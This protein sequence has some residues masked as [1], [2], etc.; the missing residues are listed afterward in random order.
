MTK[1]AGA[2]IGPFHVGTKSW[3]EPPIT[4]ECGIRE[5]EMEQ[6][7]VATALLAAVAAF[8]FDPSSAALVRS[9][10]ATQVGPLT[11]VLPQL[12][13]IAAILCLVAIPILWLKPQ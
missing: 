11:E 13:T 8:L 2:I 7:L 6:K 1:Q 4:L 3:R 12:P 10:L 9:Q 5:A